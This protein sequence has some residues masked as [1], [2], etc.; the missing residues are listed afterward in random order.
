MFESK[1]YNDLFNDL[2][3]A[4]HEHGP[5]DRSWANVPVVKDHALQDVEMLTDQEQAKYAR[6]VQLGFVMLRSC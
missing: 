5:F 3:T 4:A 2:V 6:S 1:T